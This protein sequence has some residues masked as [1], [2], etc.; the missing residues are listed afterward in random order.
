MGSS[1]VDLIIAG[2]SGGAIAGFLTVLACLGH[3][4]WCFDQKLK[5]MQMQIVALQV[6]VG[7]GE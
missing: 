6:S 1:E 5:L 2:F 7:V 3:M 4:K